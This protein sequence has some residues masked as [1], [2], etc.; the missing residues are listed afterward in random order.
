MEERMYYAIIAALIIILLPIVPKMVQVR[1]AVL[2]WL[3]WNWLADA[4]ERGFKPLVIAVRVVMV[5]IA[6]YL[7]FLTIGG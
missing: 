1:I 4:H 5:C 7:F 3:R 2:R 6:A